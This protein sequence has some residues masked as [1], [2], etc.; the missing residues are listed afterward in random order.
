MVLIEFLG[1]IARDSVELDISSLKELSIY[2]EK[3]EELKK[4]INNSAIA[5][6][7]EIVKDFNYNLKDGDKVAILPPVCGG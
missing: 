1:P 6:N 7:D 3:D 4:W 5:V 2:M